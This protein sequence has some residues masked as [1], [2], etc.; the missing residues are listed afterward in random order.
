[1]FIKA[2]IS[3]PAPF[4]VKSRVF[5]SGST[6]FLLLTAAKPK[7]RHWN[8][9]IHLKTDSNSTETMMIIIFR[10]FRRFKKFCV[11]NSV[12]RPGCLRRRR[13]RPR[14]S[15]ESVVQ[16]FFLPLHYLTTM[17]LVLFSFRSRSRTRKECGRIE[18][19]KEENFI[20]C[21][22]SSC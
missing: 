21:Q 9:F 11:T 5:D 22:T 6:F 15:R 14:T 17:K 20:G 4:C 18:H 12:R 19:I 2:F 8:W 16:I 13:R 1:M 3:F 10:N 7:S